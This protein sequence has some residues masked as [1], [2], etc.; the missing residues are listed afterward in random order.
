MTDDKLI[1]LQG[2]VKTAQ[3][4]MMSAKTKA[5]VMT[6]FE[7]LELAEKELNE[8]SDSL[9]SDEQKEAQRNYDLLL[10]EFQAKELEYKEAMET[11]RTLFPNSPSLKKV[12]AVSSGDNSNKARHLS[13]EDAQEIRKMISEGASNKEIKERFNNSDSSISYIKHYL[14]HKLRLNDEPFTPLINKFYPKK[15]KSKDGVVR[16]GAPYAEEKVKED[17]LRYKGYPEIA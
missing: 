13:Y 6:A 11:L 16:S 15:W 5:D 4:A 14:Q 2:A 7:N 17:D 9:I 1:K 12:R 8:Y 10:E 3:K